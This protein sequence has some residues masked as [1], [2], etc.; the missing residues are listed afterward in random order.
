MQVSFAYKFAHALL[1]ACIAIQYGVPVNRFEGSV[2][3]PAEPR[4]VQTLDGR[5]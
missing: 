5:R 2:R 3:C 1:A 4:C